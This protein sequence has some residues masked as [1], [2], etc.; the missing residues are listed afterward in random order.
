MGSLALIHLLEEPPGTQLL[1]T[2]Q[3]IIVLAGPRTEE[4]GRAECRYLS[5]EA[6]DQPPMGFYSVSE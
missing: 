5:M 4:V 1:S 6:L 3:H 2:A